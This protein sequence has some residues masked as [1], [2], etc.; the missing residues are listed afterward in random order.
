MASGPAA[1]QDQTDDW[2]LKVFGGAT[3]PQADDFEIATFHEER[4]EAD[5][6]FD[7]GW[8]LGAAVGRRLGRRVGIEVEF[9]YRSVEAAGRT[10]TSSQTGTA[11]SRALLINLRYDLVP[12]GP[13]GKWR[14]YLGF[15]LGAA[16]L[17][18]DD[19]SVFD[20][21]VA[22][23]LAPAYQTFAGIGY[24][25]STRFEVF[26]ELRW[27]G[28]MSAEWDDN[29]FTFDATEGTIDVLAGLRLF[30]FCE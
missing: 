15:G 1:S 19:D 23:Q 27:F 4:L 9:A 21:F 17:S 3:S 13:D 8:L 20:L 14:P 24:Q 11:D 28:V 26:G 25:V 10:R 16:D 2:Y 22:S 18:T 6:T 12:V 30:C 29:W 7:T 5:L